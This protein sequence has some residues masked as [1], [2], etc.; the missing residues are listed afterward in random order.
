MQSST[1]RF[2]CTAVLGALVASAAAGKV[3][4]HPHVFAEAR[5]EVAVAPDGQVEALRHVWRFDEMFSSTVMLEFDADT[6]NRLEEPELREIA[7]VISESIA[8]FGYFQVITANGKDIGVKPVDDMKVL[9]DDG[10]MII[11]FTTEPEEPIAITASPTFGVYDPTF[12]TAIDF[13]DDS[14]MVLE[15]APK[16]CTRTMV[17]PDPDEAIAQNQATLTEAFFSDPTGNDLSKL[18]ATRMEVNCR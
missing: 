18:L 5:L 13:Y 17:V 9:F 16:N 7:S 10:Q 6:D 15:G 1:R 14:N 2:A 8:E 4:A 11:F 3:A 12:Y